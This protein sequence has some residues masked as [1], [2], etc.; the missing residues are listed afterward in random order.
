M[1]ILPILAFSC[2]VLEYH[3]G[4]LFANHDA[5]SLSVPT[6]QLGHYGGVDNSQSFDAMNSKGTFICDGRSGG[7]GVPPF[8][9]EF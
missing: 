1:I 4:S 5:R 3:G 8:R 2:R 7:E 9:G 6:D